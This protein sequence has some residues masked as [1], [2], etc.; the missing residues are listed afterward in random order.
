MVIEAF[1]PVENSDAD[2]LLAVG[3]DLE[4]PSLINAYT[5]GIFPWPISPSIPLAWFSPNPRGVLEYEDLHVPKSLAKYLKKNAKDWRVTF[6]S[7]FA[8]VVHQCAISQN[9]KGQ[10]NQTW[11]TNDI[12]KAYLDLFYAGNAYS[13]EIW[14]DLD[15][16]GGIYGVCIG[17]FVSGESM[18]YL[19]TNASK[20]ALLTLMER[21]NTLDI[22][23]I[24]THMVTSIVSLLG[25]KEIARELFLKKLNK[26]IPLRKISSTVSKLR[27]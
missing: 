22:K 12:I 15:L 3:G 19:E 26:A 13:I 8:E 10:N 16:I 27:E 1:P 14:N 24:D 2:G 23:W 6:N 9:R 7:S 25:G 5:Q 20:F 11:I 4:I 21:L 18:F 17:S